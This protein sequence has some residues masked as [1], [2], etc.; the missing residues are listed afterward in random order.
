[1]HV[2]AVSALVIFVCPVPYKNDHKVNCKDCSGVNAVT[3]IH[4]ENLQR[5]AWSTLIFFFFT[6]STSFRWNFSHNNVYDS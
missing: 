5:D 2:T 4:L 3:H 1:M 6:A